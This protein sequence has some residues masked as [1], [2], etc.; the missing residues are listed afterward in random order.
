MLIF[1]YY[2]IKMKH[3]T[4]VCW[5]EHRFA[6]FHVSNIL[7]SLVFYMSPMKKHLLM[8]QNSLRPFSF[9]HVHITSVPSVYV[10]W[11][12]FQV[13]LHHD[14]CKW[15][16]FSTSTSIR[17]QVQ[18]TISITQWLRFKTLPALPAFPA[19]CISKLTPHSPPR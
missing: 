10:S 17:V 9:L 13:W 1:T 7:A 6:I 11:C 4:V 8:N 18:H 12:F 5:T 2:L 3:L 19:L 16:W 15:W 14:W